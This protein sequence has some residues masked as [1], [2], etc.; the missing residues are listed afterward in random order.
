MENFD[1]RKYLAEGR[2]LK[3][4]DSLDSKLNNLEGVYDSEPQISTAVFNEEGFYLTPLEI[5]DI[6]DTAQD[7]YSEYQ[8]QEKMI[9]P[10]ASSIIKK[11]K[12]EVTPEIWKKWVEYNDGDDR[13]AHILNLFNEMYNDGTLGL[14]EGRLFEENEPG[15]NTLGEYETTDS[16]KVGDEVDISSGVQGKA[17]YKAK[18][19]KINNEDYVTVEISEDRP[20]IIDYF[21]DKYAK[22]KTIKFPV[23]RVIPPSISWRK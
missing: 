12:K 1:L 20:D 7:E 13:I 9:G 8:N 6:K 2:L 18:I 17:K 19:T 14:A 21:G 11:F 5:D 10:E 4:D 3:E 23:S 16:L 22:G 15:I